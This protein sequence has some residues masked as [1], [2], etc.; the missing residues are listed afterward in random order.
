LALGEVSEK[1][2]MERRTGRCSIGLNSFKP[3]NL[4]SHHRFI[5]ISLIIALY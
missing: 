5:L 1:L 2:L 3:F 4:F